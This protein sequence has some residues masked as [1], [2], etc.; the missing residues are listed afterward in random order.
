[1]TNINKIKND[2]WEAANKLRADSSL[3][4]NEFATPVLGLI[5][6]R[7]ADFKFFEAKKILD[8]ELPKLSQRQRACFNEP[9]WFHAK[10]ILYLKEECRFSYLLNLSESEDLGKK[11]EDAM[12]LIEQENKS[13]NG[14]L[15]KNF[16]R[17]EKNLLF[18]L[19]KIFS[20]MEIEKIEGDAFGKIYEYFLGKFAGSEGQRGGEF[21]T[22]TSLV[23]LIV[24]VLKPIN[25]KLFDPACGSG[26]M[27]VQSAEF[28]KRRHEIP[29]EKISIYGQEITQETQKLCLMNLAIH[30]L[31]G[32]IKLGNTFYEDEHKSLGKFDFV[33]ANPPFNVSGFDKERLKGDQRYFLGIPKVD[34]ANYLWI[35]DFYTSLNHK[36]KAG[37]VMANSASDA[38]QSEQDIRAKIV[39]AGAVDAMISIGSNFFH[40]VTLPCT[41]WFFDKGKTQNERKNQ[42]LFLD[43]RQ[44]YTQIDRAHREF[45][46]SQIEHIANIVKLYRGDEPTFE[47]C[48]KSDFEI[49]FPKLKY[50]D[51][52]GLCKVATIAEIAAQNYSLNAGRYVGTADAIEQNYVFEERLKDLND[53]LLKLNSESRDLETKIAN[54]ISQLITA[55]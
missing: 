46:E 31:E 33:M 3:K 22:P 37:F 12:S 28:I 2:L 9:N 6:L 30:G 34:N 55:K 5:F 11:L 16:S 13:L 29:N 7:Y 27:F 40:N 4:T 10:G 26:G 15:P 42:T 20:K 24:E 8:N 39:E 54:N 41:L 49:Q 23:R 25:G 43:A 14:V 48:Q 32:Q 52:L 45:S 18:A 21:F 47:F 44:I 53:E 1:M 38:R 35:Q 36:G 19:M 50:H 17:I 51:I